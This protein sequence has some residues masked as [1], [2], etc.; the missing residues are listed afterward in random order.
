MNAFSRPSRRTAWCAAIALISALMPATAVVAEPEAEPTEAASITHT[1]ATQVRVSKQLGLDLGVSGLGDSAAEVQ[2]EISTNGGTL[3]GADVTEFAGSL[4]GLEEWLGAWK[5]ISDV[6]TPG[7]VTVEVRVVPKSESSVIYD[8]ASDRYYESVSYSGVSWEAAATAASG[9]SL[10]GLQGYLA[11]ITSAEEQAFLDEHAELV[12]G[13]WLGGRANEDRVWTWQTGPEVGEQF[14]PC[15]DDL[16]RSS[17]AGP[18][19]TCYSNWSDNE[20]NNWNKTEDAL[21][22]GWGGDV[23]TG[24]WND[25]NKDGR[26]DKGHES[27]LGYL[28]EYGGMTDD[29]NGTSATVTFEVEA[30]A[31]ELQLVH[32]PEDGFVGRLH[33]QPSV[34]LVD[35]DGNVLADPHDAFDVTVSVNGP[36]G[37]ELTGDTTVSTTD[38][39]ASFDDLAIST[40]GTY[41]LTFGVEERF[42]LASVKTAG[43]SEPTVTPV[44]SEEFELRRRPVV[45]PPTTPPPVPTPTGDL[46][47]PVVG[48]GYGTIGD[49]P[50]DVEVGGD[51]RGIRIHGGSLTL[52][53]A[54][55][56]GQGNNAGV[57]SGTSL[58]APATAGVNITGEG[59]RPGTKAAAWLF[60]EPV[61][62]GEFDVDAQGRIEGFGAFPPDVLA[63]GHTIQVVGTAAD[64]EQAALSFGVGI[65]PDP[66]PYADV[67][68]YGDNGHVVGC[69]TDRGIVTGYGDGTFGDEGPVLRSQAASIIARALELSGNEDL[70]FTDTLP[71]AH[72]DGIRA[73]AAA[74]YLRGYADGSFGGT[75]SLTRGQMASLFAAVLGLD[76]AEDAGFTDVDGSAHAGAINAITDTGLVNTFGDATFR[77]RQSVTRAQFTSMVLRMLSLRGDA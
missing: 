66:Y 9:R 50:I 2:A 39:V 19:S 56:D 72:A 27:V 15:L 59:F 34:Q 57:V 61:L 62:L 53:A 38:G 68:A 48:D 28:V 41:T 42:A 5:W 43:T 18:A 35:F 75:R 25:Y 46:P 23:L 71:A 32:E 67:E 69:A 13:L 4:E 11:T 12:A 73:V 65:V 58:L 24:E 45:A 60:S 54:P 20:P 74:G 76:P 77:P 17:T 70:D 33:P 55:E 8:E 52:D 6:P 51:G 26:P 40:P 49:T 64:G 14:H 29:V 47:A 3:V 31:D 21:I 7:S 30:V 36:K 1:N 16:K 10:H 44:T 22:I 37:A 63:C